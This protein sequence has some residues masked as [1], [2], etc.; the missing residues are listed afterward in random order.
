M[1][2][3]PSPNEI[4][5]ILPITEQLKQQLRK[6]VIS[7]R[8]V[9]LRKDPRFVLVVGPCSIHNVES[10]YQ[11]ALKLK[12]LA[13]ELKDSM[14]IVMRCYVEKARTTTGWKGLA[15][16]PNLNDSY[17]I[18]DGIIQSRRLMLSI[19]ELG[20]PIAMEFVNPLIAPY[21]S[22]LITW[23]FIGARTPTSQI[24]REL[25]SSLPIPMG[26]KNTLSGDVECALHGIHAASHPHSFLKIE[27]S[28]GLVQSE[29]K[30]NPFC[31]LVLRGSKKHPNYDPYTVDK[32]F[33]SQVKMGIHSPIMIDCSHG[34][35]KKEESLQKVVFKNV[36]RQYVMK[37]PSI[38]GA[39][40]ESHHNSGRQH[41]EL[42]RNMDPDISITDPCISFDE[43][44]ELS[45]WA[46]G[47][48][49]ESHTLAYTS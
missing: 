43:T 8:E 31:H 18:T 11:Y 4:C 21:F 25:S 32:I 38:L 28:G 14:F 16:D 9:L 2:R 22:D 36:A 5:E 6:Q 42:D 12:E 41:F 35:C 19:T 1:T 47:I 29:S 13:N 10:A 45:R 46:H 3:I 27:D 20:L 39:M 40:I 37:G 34:N 48:L 17:D 24:H 26:F 15:Y 30:G 7:A 49:K 44:V 23:G 33:V